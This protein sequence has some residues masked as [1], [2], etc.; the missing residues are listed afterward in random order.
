MI[1]FLHHQRN[2]SH[3]VFFL[4][5]HP[6]SRLNDIASNCQEDY[7]VVLAGNKLDLRNLRL[8]E[9]NEVKRMA[10]YRNIKYFECSTKENY[11][12][13]E[14]LECVVD[15]IIKNMGITFDSIKVQDGGTSSMNKCPC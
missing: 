5:Y 12:V 4:L 11:N 15:L 1:P 7:A 3:I 2:K 14:T 6:S 13:I 8:V 10:E 9:N